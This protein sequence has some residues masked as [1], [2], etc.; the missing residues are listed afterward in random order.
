MHYFTQNTSKF[1]GDGAML[2][3]HCVCKALLRMQRLSGA[4]DDDDDDDNDYE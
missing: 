3:I 1:S 4:L 2:Y